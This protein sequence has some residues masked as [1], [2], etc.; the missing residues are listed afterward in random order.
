RGKLVLAAEPS[1]IWRSLPSA[2]RAACP[3][4]ERGREDAPDRNP[5]L[6]GQSAAKG[7][8]DGAGSRLRTGLSGLLVRISA[9]PERSRR[10]AG[11]V[12]P[13]HVDE[14]WLGTGAGYRKFFRHHR[15]WS[16]ARDP[17][18]EGTRWGGATTGRKVVER[19]R[20]GSGRCLP[21]EV[22]HAARRGG[23]TA[24]GERLLA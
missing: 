13:S 23:V 1:Q 3:H 22:R 24:A 8:D 2:A 20:D 15:P 6:R 14:R 19:R 5:D 9:R 17:S 12:A 16:A 21:P 7:G 11:I 18:Q 10:A 4:S